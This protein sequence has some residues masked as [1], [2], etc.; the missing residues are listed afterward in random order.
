MCRAISASETPEPQRP[1]ALV[2]GEFGD[3]LADDLPVEP[4]RA[5]LLERDRPADLTA[6]LLQ[7]LVVDLAEL[8]D[9]DL[10]TADLGSVERPKPRKM[11]PMPQIAKLITSRPMTP[12]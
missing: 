3:H 10:G 4:E 2:E 6:D 11:S 12:P 9:A 5:R 1:D 7:P 8:L